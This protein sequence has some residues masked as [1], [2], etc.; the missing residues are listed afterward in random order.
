MRFFNCSIDEAIGKFRLKKIVFFGCG[1]WLNTINFSG[2]MALKNNFNYA[3]DNKYTG[4]VCLG[5]KKLEV[6]PPSVL[7][8]EKDCIVILTSP[9]YMYDMYCQLKDLGVDDSVYCYAFPFMQLVT[10]KSDSVTLIE[11]VTTC[12]KPKI[13][14]VIHCFWFSGDEK[15]ENYKRCIETWKEY[16]S[17]Y[18]IIEWNQNNYDCNKHP[19]LRRAIDCG[20]WAFASDFARLDVLNEYGGIYLDMDVEV[21]KSFDTLLENEAILSF[22]NNVQID[23]AVMG[24]VP[25]NAIIQ[26]LL[27]IY[28]GVKIPDIKK[29]FSKFFQPTL[30]KPTLVDCGIRMDGT[31]QIVEGATVFSNEFFM[32]QDHVLFRPYIRTNHTYCN[33]LDNFGWSFSGNNKKEKKIHDNSILW[34]KIER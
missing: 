26:K 23:L 17:E 7:K 3:I 4:I 25:H 33:H 32:P 11:K 14:K 28:D 8:D 19:F 9:V 31:L 30:V 16:L 29:E 21:F 20:A 13:P 18:K 24:A 34:N 12:V 10:K 1:S 22:S 27:T 5:E 2:F 15:P 6:L